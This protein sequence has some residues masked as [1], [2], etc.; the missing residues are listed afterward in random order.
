AVTGWVLVCVAEDQNWGGGSPDGQ[1][2]HGG[3][4]VRKRLGHHACATGAEVLTPGEGD[5]IGAGF[6]RDRDHVV[7]SHA[8]AAQQRDAVVRGGDVAREELLLPCPGCVRVV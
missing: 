3:V 2:Q 4:A 6:A 8:E 5:Q 7:G 1:Q